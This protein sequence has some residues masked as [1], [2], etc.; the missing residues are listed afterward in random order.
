MKSGFHDLPKK[1]YSRKTFFWK[2]IFFLTVFFSTK[3][4]KAFFFLLK[5]I[6]E[7]AHYIAFG[8]DA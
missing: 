5:I 6:F 1:S 4:K 8:Y 2:K 7:W 3:S